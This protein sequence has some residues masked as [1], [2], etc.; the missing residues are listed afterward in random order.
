[1]LLAF[2]FFAQMTDLL[3]FLSMGREYE[4]NPFVLGISTEL[5]VVAKL[6]LAGTIVGV[7]AVLT[8]EN[9]YRGLMIFLLG[10]GFVMGSIG[11]ISNTLVLAALEI[12][13]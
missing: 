4:A 10:F 13:R 2:A 7:T 12:V 3:S 6:T 8:R 11:T 9:K 1:M 5:A